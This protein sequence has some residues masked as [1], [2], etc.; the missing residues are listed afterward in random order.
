MWEIGYVGTRGVKFPMHRRFNLPSRET[1]ER[2]N[3]LII[4]GGPY[5][6]DMGES[7]MNHSL[8][9][10]VRKRFSNRL[11]FDFHY[12]WGKTMAYT[13]GDV[14]VY[15]GTDATSGTQDF[16]NLA[17]ERGSPSFDTTHRAVG[18]LIYELPR[19]TN[20]SAPLRGT[21]DGPALFFSYEGLC[22]A[23]PRMR[24][25]RPSPNSFEKQ[26]A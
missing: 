3:P 20:L 10:S 8:Q 11:S 24:R 14:G 1:R 19:F 18:D 21:G 22:M 26:A 4:P 16:F 9:T 25:R 17:I 7:V 12:T 2:P 13:G 23:C 6:V 15:Y 5:F